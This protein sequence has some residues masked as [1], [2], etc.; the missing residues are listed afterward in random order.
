[1]TSA[2]ERQKLDAAIRRVVERNACIGCGFCTSL[3]PSLELRLDADGFLRPHR[4]GAAGTVAEDAARTFEQACPGC[5]VDAVRPPGSR[6]HPT[7]G[8]YFG[9]WEAWASDEAVRYRGSSGGA[10]TALHGWLLESGRASRIASASVGS[11]PRRTVPVTIT[12]KEAALAAAGSRYA[13]VGVLSNRDTW[14]S[15]AITAKPCEISAVRAAAGASGRPSDA[16]HAILLSFFCAGTP[17]QDATGDL[18]ARLEVPAD[19]PVDELW[20]RGRGWPGRFTVRTARAEA[21]LSYD[22][23]WGDVLGPATH[24]RCKLC[25]DGVGESADVVAADL[26]SVDDRGYPVFTEGPGSSG[27]IARTQRGLEAVN[28][29]AAAGAIVVRSIRMSELANAQP[30]QRKRRLS[31]FGR[32]LGSRLAGV[33]GPRYRGFR[34]WALALAHPRLNLRAARG[35][36]ARIRRSTATTGSAP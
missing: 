25:P 9:V 33:R 27:L 36:R 26:W 8:S 14:S 31:L 24:W 23:S 13:P 18:L 1:M 12:T 21:S 10:L 19:G 16:E 15:E 22:E 4:T 2:R 20:Y 5:R 34:L 7:M 11:E 17:S 28:A 3:D 6:R 30:L 32:L 29:A 35:T